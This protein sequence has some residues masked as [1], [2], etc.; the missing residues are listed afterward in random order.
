M[1]DLR[2]MPPRCLRFGELEIQG[3]EVELDVF[4]DV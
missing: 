2:P 3:G 4:T 1:T